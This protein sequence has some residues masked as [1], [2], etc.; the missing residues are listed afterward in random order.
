MQIIKIGISVNENT[1][2]ECK[3]FFNNVKEF[4][5]RSSIDALLFL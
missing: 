3:S 4:Y 2:N 1:I 5:K